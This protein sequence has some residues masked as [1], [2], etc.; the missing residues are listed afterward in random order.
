YFCAFPFLVWAVAGFSP[1]PI[2][3]RINLWLVGLLIF[4]IAAITFSE[5]PIY[6]EWHHKLTYKAIWY[7]RNPSEVFHTASWSQLI[8]GLLAIG[9]L[10]ALGV[11]AYRK[12]FPV[13]QAIEKTSLLKHILFVALTPALFVLGIRG[14]YQ[15][16]PVQVSDA[17]YSSNNFLNTVSVNS[18]FHLMGNIFW[19]ANAGKPYAFM[20]SADAEKI[21][22]ALHAVEKDTT[23]HFLTTDKPNVVLVVL[24]GWS[25]DLVERLGGYAGITP[26]TDAMMREGISFDSCYASGSLSDQGMAAVFSGFPAQP[27][28]SI[29]T[30]PEKYMHLPCLNNGFLKAGYQTSY[31]FGGQ[32]S[33]GNIRSYMYYNKFHKIIEGK[34]FDAAIPQGRLGAHDQYLFDRQLQELKGTQTPFFAAMFTLS[35]HGPFDIPMA[36]KLQWGD[37]E[38]DYIN[39]ALYA[40][41]CI[42]NF[43]EAAKKEPWYANTLFVFVPDHSHNSPR[44]WAFNQ[45]EYR[46]IPFWFYGPVIRPEFRGYRS[47]KI[48]SQTDLAATLLHQLNMDASAFRYSKNLFNPYTPELAFY[49][50]DE[51]FGIIRPEGRLIWHVQDN[52]TDFERVKDAASKTKILNEGKAYLQVLMEEYW[53][54]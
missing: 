50:F 26:H 44:N 43:L 47:K 1:K 38:K 32:L 46:R 5:L 52:K 53:R 11:W 30:L 34:D 45:P 6:D 35:T 37:K 27:K 2:F 25:A 29:I 16:I 7:L 13:V 17:Y 18:T 22:A 24:E 10:T 28:T 23:I 9:L 48:C 40:D 3:S 41:E 33:Y 51:G 4:L 20:P 14:G 36:S 19:N 54:Y 49:T 21:V 12:L 8:F 31:M 42:H 15:P 39:S